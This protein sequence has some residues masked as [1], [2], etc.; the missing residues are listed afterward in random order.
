MTYWV[1]ELVSDD[2]HDSDMTADSLET[3]LDGLDAY[4]ASENTT[5]CVR[6]LCRDGRGERGILFDT[7]TTMLAVWLRREFRRLGAAR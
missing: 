7:R 6:I 3:L 5:A 1:Q 4:L 2:W